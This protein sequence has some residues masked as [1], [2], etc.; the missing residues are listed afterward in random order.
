MYFRAAYQQRTQ[1]C[2][3]QKQQ[4]EMHKGTNSEVLI[5]NIQDMHSRYSNSPREGKPINEDVSYKYKF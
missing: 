4:T 5:F 1:L 2:F 3:A